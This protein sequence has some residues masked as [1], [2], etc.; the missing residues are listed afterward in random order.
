MDTMG[1]DDDEPLWSLVKRSESRAAALAVPVAV[2]RDSAADSAAREEAVTQQPAQPVSPF[3]ISLTQPA[4]AEACMSHDEGSGPHEG[5]GR[6]QAA[7]LAVPERA[8]AVSLEAEVAALTED[9]AQDDDSPF[10]P[11]LRRSK[12]RQSVIAQ[13]FARTHGRATGS[14][15]PQDSAS[16]SAAS[17]QN[18]PAE[19]ATASV[20]TS[21]AQQGEMQGGQ[22]ASSQDEEEAQLP[23]RRAR[24]RATWL[25]Y[26]QE[27]EAGRLASPLQ[28]RKWRPA[29]RLGLSPSDR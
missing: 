9:E 17:Q 8:P 26:T 10:V 25:H 12:R 27:R 1:D 13:G 22:P 3:E 4:P 29:R 6:E 21:Q 18:D 16:D 7:A 15:T 5:A 11:R 2:Q 14:S 20:A 24:M 23:S 19:H 28:F